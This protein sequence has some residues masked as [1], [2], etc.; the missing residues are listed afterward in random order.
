MENIRSGVTVLLF[1]SCVAILS[2]FTFVQRKRDTKGRPS[3]FLALC[4]LCVVVYDF[5]YAMEIHARTLDLIMFWVR[6]EQLGIQLLPP[7]WFL[8]ALGIIMGRKKPIGLLPLILLFAL[9]LAGLVCSQTLG[10]LNIMHPNPRLASTELLSRFEYDRS[11][12][13][14]VD[15]AFQSVYLL[16]GFAFFSVALIRGSPVPRSQAAIY[17][18]GSLIPWLSSFAYVLGVSPYNADLTPI[19]LSISIVLFLLGF[20]KVGLLDI[21][22][23]A[24]NLIFEGLE[25]G[26]LVIDSNGLFMDK[27]AS[28]TSILPILSRIEAGVPAA[29]IITPDSSLAAMLA[30]SP[31]ASM[32]FSIGTG[33]SRRIFNVAYTA[34]RDRRER[35]IGRLLSFHNVT[36]RK[37]L[38][39]RLEE[40]SIHDELTGLYNR[41]HLVESANRYMDEARSEG[42][43]FSIVILDLD[44][45]KNVNDT[46][47][48]IVGDHVLV[49]TARICRSSVREGDIVGRLGGEEFLVLMPGTDLSEAWKIAERIRKELELNF[50]VFEGREIRVTAS[51][52]VA[53]IC[54]YCQ[55]LEDI[56]ITADKGLYKAKELGRNRVCLGRPRNLPANAEFPESY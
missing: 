12:V 55:T 49:A 39:T 23:L 28:M 11:W 9:P 22:P 51:F 52:G 27:N 43:E 16:A 37:M 41:R 24:R 4:G 15:T 1:T 2:L 14:Y 31:P 30:P 32:E 17:T 26:I 44:H 19:A 13:M 47:G 42:K 3:L 29:E 56:L 46:Y 45:F 48:H 10:T 8:F 34:L 7:L 6:F 5:G 18:L 25:D 36:E 40:I 53:S 50:V 38:Q 35:N 33:D 54:P 21:T 20:L